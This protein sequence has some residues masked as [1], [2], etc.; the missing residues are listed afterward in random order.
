MKLYF[1]LFLAALS[2]P[3]ASL[4][5]VCALEFEVVWNIRQ[6]LG[7]GVV[8]GSVMI[9]LALIMFLCGI[10]STLQRIRAQTNASN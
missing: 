8:V 4:A 7:I 9:L 6:A 2:M 10:P 3:L 5:G 1:G